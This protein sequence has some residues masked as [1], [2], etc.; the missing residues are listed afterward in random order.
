[1]KSPSRRSKALEDLPP[2]L[3]KKFFKKLLEE[4]NMLE[5]M[6]YFVMNKIFRNSAEDSAMINY[7]CY[8]T[9]VPLELFYNPMAVIEELNNK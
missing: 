7:A 3:C 1:L 2:K 6:V 9:N 8:V 4:K 5:K